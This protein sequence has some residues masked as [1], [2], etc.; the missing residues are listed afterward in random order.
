VP[1]AIDDNPPAP[2]PPPETSSQE[3]R[4]YVAPAEPSG[5]E[6]K[7]VVGPHFVVWH[8]TSDSEEITYTT[9]VALGASARIEAIRW[10]GVRLMFSRGTQGVD[11]GNTALGLPTANLE[12]PALSL[13]QLALRVELTWVVLPRLRLWG[14]PSAAWIHA[15]APSPK[16]S[17]P[18]E[19]K[20]SR[21]TG[22]FV[23]LGGALGAT[24]DVIPHWLA[25]TAALSAGAITDE[26]GDLFQ[27][28]QAV[29]KSGALAEIAPL[30][31][32]GAAFAAELGVGIIL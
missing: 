6:R 20:T 29:S 25:V 22:V 21:R 11:V 7:V 1:D 23:E 5:P 27:P 2:P 32:L 16:T 4:P 18:A 24:L 30:P 3:P 17:G 26:N 15:E 31:E 28:L 13:D 12:Q 8:R 14:G 19:V 9:G 10:L